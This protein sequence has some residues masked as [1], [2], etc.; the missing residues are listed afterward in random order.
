M[1]PKSPQFRL[2]HPKL[3]Q[4]ITLS[5]VFILQIRRKC[6]TYRRL[7]EAASETGGSRDR[8]AGAGA[9]GETRGSLG[10]TAPARGKPTG[11]AG[12]GDQ[13][14]D[15]GV[16]AGDLFHG[17][18]PVNEFNI[19][20]DFYI[21]FYFLIISNIINFLLLFKIFNIRSVLYKITDT[22]N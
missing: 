7:G 9:L 5:V 3:L 19:N 14:V 2:H 17:V 10:R 12:S 13:G 11:T 4:F 18:Q 6:E 15:S 16:V 22:R 20:Q 8:E 21:F 1:K